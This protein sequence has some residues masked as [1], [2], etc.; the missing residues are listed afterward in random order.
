MHEQGWTTLHD[1]Q[2]RAIGPIADGNRDVIISAATA[3][4]KTEA[5]F[6]PIC[7]V[8]TEARDV[9]AAEA[10]PDP[11]EGHDPWAPPSVPPPVGIEVLYLSPLKALINDQYDRLEQLCERSDIAVHRWHGDISSSAKRTTMKRPSGVLLITPESLEAQFVNRGTELPTVL[12]GLRY[13]VIDELHSFL[14]TPRGAQLQSLM[15]RVELAV[16]RRVPR[17]GLSATLGDMTAATE[18]LRPTAPDNVAVIESSAEGQELRLQLRGYRATA[19]ELTVRQADHAAAA[20]T[21]VEIEQTV[22]GDRLD[23]AAH[24]FRTLRGHDNLVFANARRDVELY[25]DLLARQSDRDRVPNEFWPHHGSLAKDVREV[26]EAQLKDRSRP[27]TAVCTS[28][29]EMGIDIGSVASVA[30]IGPPPSVA[31]LRQRLGR[32][33]RRGEPAVVRLYVTEDE[34]DGRSALIDELRSGLVQTVAMVRLLL[35]RWLEAPDDPGLNLSTLM[36][37]TLSVI[38][39]HGGATAAELHGALCG[40]GPFAHVDGNRFGRLLRAMAAADLIVQSGDGTLLHGVAGERIVNHYS[41]YSAFHT[42]EEWRLV[43]DGRPLGTLPITQPLAEGGLLIFAGR[44]WKITGVDSTARVVELTRAAGGVPPNFGGAAALVGDRVRTEMVDVY[45]SAETPSW[46]DS[47]AQT[48]LAE[49]RAAWQRL[50]LDEVTL[51]ATGNDTV[52]LPWVG[53]RALATAAL[54]LGSR[55]LDVSVD[56]PA[57]TVTDADPA[58]VVA[59]AT[60]LLSVPS[61]DPVELA[62]LVENTE[63]DKWDWVLDADLAAEATAARLLDVD[64]AWSVLRTIADR[65]TPVEHQTPSPEAATR[66]GGEAPAAEPPP[67]PAVRRSSVRSQPASLADQEFCVID[68]E[69]TGFSPRLGDRIVEIAAVRMKGSGTVLGEWTTLVNPARDIGA[70]HVHGITAGDVLDAPSF[71]DVAGDLLALLD[72]AVVAAHNVRFDWSFVADEYA[73]AGHFLPPLPAV[74]TLALGTQLHPDSASRKLAVCCEQIGHQIP[75]AHAALHDARAA[76]ALLAAYLD[77]G[78]RA[79]LGNLAE[80]GCVPL[81]WPEQVPSLSPS[82]RRRERTDEQR[83]VTEAASYLSTLVAQLDGVVADSDTAAYLDVL[84]R[85]LEDRHLASEEA[86]ALAATATEWGLTAA[87]VADLH[88]SYFDSVVAAALADGIVTAAERTDLERVAALL[89]LPV[90][91]VDDAVAAGSAART[92]A[93]PGATAGSLSGLS[94]CFTGT[95]TGTIDGQQITRTVAQGLARD[96]GLDVRKSVTRDLDLLVV[97]DPDSLSGKAQ[98]ARDLGTRIIAESVFWS[99]IGAAAH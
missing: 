42:P 99:M 66:V 46:L 82:G 3:A 75:T 19:P 35:E 67:P 20:G 6:L 9:V 32:S 78:A 90:S 8:L 1:A 33:G 10:A 52:A 45:R 53:D 76:A 95:L 51:I 13:V 7:S 83:H 63:I 94:V 55:S 4:G 68:V 79:G 37:Q 34:I 73:R 96:A 22:G 71:S 50:R 86:D 93:G 47:Q 69:T 97:A 54:A 65:P 60:D 61:P 17:I 18:F 56:G 2:E 81:T 30:Q 43:A 40:P 74:C 89:G 48:L 39:Q 5:A 62:R 64:G 92:G 14:S 31:S 26:V 36:Q 11:W 91:T 72:G 77:D 23:I 16:R 29:L 27:V 24:L 58:D 44:R 80:I 25:A 59:A 84:D 15:Q 70:T 98:R 57:L 85:A 38:A 88:R 41:F 21:S 12:A 28:T 49:G 87:A